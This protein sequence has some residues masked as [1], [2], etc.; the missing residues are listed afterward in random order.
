MRGAVSAVGLGSG[1]GARSVTV[2]EFDPGAVAGL[3][4]AAPDSARISCVPSAS[5][6]AAA[7]RR[8][9]EPDPGTITVALSRRIIVALSG[10][11]TKVSSTAGGRR[12]RR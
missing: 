7:G 2:P 10:R 4:S 9:G 5:A 3:A 11:P 12:R 6:G 8:A 1:G